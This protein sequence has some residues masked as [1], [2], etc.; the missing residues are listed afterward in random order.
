MSSTE[1][2][3]IT[4]ETLQRLLYD[5]KDIM[6]NP[7]HEQGIYYTHDETNMLKGYA[8]IIGPTNTPYQYG[9]YFF[10]ID[11]PTDY[12]ASPPKVIY[13]TNS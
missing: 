2:K 10:D 12:P 9:Y 7:L 3:F 5:V 11:Y 1:D 4:K 8:L 6:K 13:K